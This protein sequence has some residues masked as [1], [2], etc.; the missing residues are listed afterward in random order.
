[1]VEVRLDDV[2][3]L[4][5]GVKEV[6]HREIDGHG[7]EDSLTQELQGS[8]KSASHAEAAKWGE[9]LHSLSQVPRTPPSVHPLPRCPLWGSALWAVFD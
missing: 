5:P 8:E 6:W 1:M 2:G 9:A 7:V 4:W 3:E